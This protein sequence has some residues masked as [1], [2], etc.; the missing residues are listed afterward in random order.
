MN[1]NTFNT[2]HFQ[3]SQDYHDTDTEL[4]SNADRETDTPTTET[5]VQ[6]YDDISNQ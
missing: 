3:A 5:L 6:L 2:L 4:T 1:M